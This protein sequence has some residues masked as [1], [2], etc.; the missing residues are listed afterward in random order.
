MLRC[1]SAV[2]E[3]PIIDSHPKRVD[4]YLT[5]P[6]DLDG[7][8]SMGDNDQPGTLRFHSG[9]N[10]SGIQ[11]TFRRMLMPFDQLS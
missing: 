2:P 10:I 1:D 11:L 9:T 4:A 8:S 7:I 6:L 3:H 5:S